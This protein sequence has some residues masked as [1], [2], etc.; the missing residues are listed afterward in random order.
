MHD[1]ISVVGGKI[2]RSLLHQVC[3][4][5]KIQANLSAESKLTAEV[6]HPGN[7]RRN[8]AKALAIFALS[9]IIAI[10]MHFPERN[11]AAGFLQFFNI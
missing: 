3:K 9:T 10:R 8:V 5:R 4:G 11:Y 7:Y 6:F 1:S 2:T